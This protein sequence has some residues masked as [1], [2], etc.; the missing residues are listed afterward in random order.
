MAHNGSGQTF[1]NNDEEFND[2][3]WER[4]IKKK[5]ERDR[6]RERERERVEREDKGRWTIRERVQWQ[7]WTSG[8]GAGDTYNDNIKKKALEEAHF[9]M[10]RAPRFLSETSKEG[11][12]WEWKAK[13]RH[14]QIWFFKTFFEYSISTMV[15]LK[16]VV[17]LQFQWR[18]HENRHWNVTYIYKNV[19]IILTTM[20]LIKFSL[21]ERR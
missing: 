10:Q 5:R 14:I 21:N 3:Q 15:F 2:G 7:H 12:S 8:G 1:H 16:F 9:R 6:E 17:D 19:T 20:I 11:T 13:I 4:K 18:F